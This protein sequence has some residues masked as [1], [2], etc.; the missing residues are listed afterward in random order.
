MPAEKPSQA[1][2]LGGVGSEQKE[3][4]IAWWSVMQTVWGTGIYEKVAAAINE[5]REI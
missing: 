1:Q 2:V 5:M 3:A 4:A